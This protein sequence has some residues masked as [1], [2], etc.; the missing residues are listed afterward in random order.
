MTGYIEYISHTQRKHKR[1][2]Q[3]RLTGHKSKTLFKNNETK[4]AGDE[5]QVPAWQTQGPK[6]KPQNCKKKKKMLTKNKYKEVK[7][8]CTENSKTLMKENTKG[9]TSYVH[10]MED[11]K[12]TR[13][14]KL[15]ENLCQL[16]NR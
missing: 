6:F 16:F 5:A 12:W 7:Y 13:Q 4:R 14:K 11:L 15:G 1:S 10:G 9:K 2:S 3:C 8:L